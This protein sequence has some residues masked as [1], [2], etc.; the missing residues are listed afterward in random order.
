MNWT[1]FR[2]HEHR[3][4]FIREM[5]LLQS[6][7]H[8]NVLEYLG[9]SCVFN[10]SELVIGIFCKSRKLFLV[11]EFLSGGHLQSLLMNTSQPL[12]WTQRCRIGRDV[13]SGMAYVHNQNIIH[14]DL[15]VW[16]HNP[17]VFNLLAVRKYN[18]SRWWRSSDCWLW[19]SPSHA[20]YSTELW[21]Y[22]PF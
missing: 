13:A 17:F 4:T 20:W 8:Q 11:T 19:A 21:H 18:A 6:L 16:S 9:M 14:R 10:W 7:S 3:S 2:D 12:F 5:N 15:K 22:Q 1:T